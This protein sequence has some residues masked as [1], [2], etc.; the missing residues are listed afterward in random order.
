MNTTS[1]CGKTIQPL[2]T[3]MKSYLSASDAARVLNLSAA[4]VRQMIRRGT[5][6]VA[7]RTEGGIQLL[8]R[9]DVERLAMRRARA[10]ARVS[11]DQA[12]A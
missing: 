8:R 5:I 10:A 9:A 11:R 4:T 12:V 1:L 2:E 6:P 3:T 7:A